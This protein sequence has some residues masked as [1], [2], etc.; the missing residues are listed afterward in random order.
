MNTVAFI[1]NQLVNIHNLYHEIVAD[2]T[3]QEWTARLAPNQNLIGFTVW[4]MPRTQDS[5]VQLWTRGIP[6]VF[7]EA[8]WSN[9]QSLQ[10]LGIGTG[11][12]QSEA[13]EIAAT[14][15]LSETLA[16][17][18]AVHKEILTWLRQLNDTD[19]DQ[20]PDIAAHLAE[21]PEYQAKGFRAETDAMRGQPIWNLFMRPCIGHL[22]RHLGE[23]ALLKAM[24]RAHS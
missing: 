6:E 13:D 21:Y 10:R 2:F 17:E 23:L 7:H 15:H 8:R 3:E 19:L 5:I 12:T 1:E 14:V 16:Y 22:H 11:V 20:I 24:L 4:H 18:E 9:W